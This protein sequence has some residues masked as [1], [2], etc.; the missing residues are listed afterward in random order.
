[1]TPTARVGQRVQFRLTVTNT[2]PVAAREVQVADVPPA[3]IALA[4]F[5]SSERSRVV[6]GNALWNLGTLEPGASR[7]ITG[8]VRIRSGTPGRKRNHVLASAANA[9]V[10]DDLADTRLRA[11]RAPAVTGR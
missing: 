3:A 7:T 1:M 2:G 9:K 11:R 5:R 8:S 4:S 6:R 10:V